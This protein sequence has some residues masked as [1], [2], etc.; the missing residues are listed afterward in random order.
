[1]SDLGHPEAVEVAIGI[2]RHRPMAVQ[3]EGGARLIG[4]VELVQEPAVEGLDENELDMMVGS[5]RMFDTAD[6]DDE[7]GTLAN[8]K[9]VPIIGGMHKDGEM[10]LD[11]A[12]GRERDKFGHRLATARGDDTRIDKLNDDVATVLAEEK[13]CFHNKDG[14]NG[15]VMV[16]TKEG[17]KWKS[18]LK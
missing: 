4:R 18:R 7:V 17:Q 16:E 13:F 14:F 15:L 1:M 9:R 6:L 12:I 3:G 11:R 8:G 5:H 10:F 2:D